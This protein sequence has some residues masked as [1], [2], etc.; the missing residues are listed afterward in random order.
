M[1]IE[2]LKSPADLKALNLEAL[3]WWPPKPEMP[4]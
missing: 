3:K 1:Y 2:K 4:S